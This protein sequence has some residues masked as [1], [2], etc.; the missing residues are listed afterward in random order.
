MQQ[1]KTELEE[2]LHQFITTWRLLARP[3]PH[4]DLSDQ[5][6]LAVSWPSTH[7]PFYNIVFL[8][9]ELKDEDVFRDRVREAVIHLRSSQASGLFLVCSYNLFCHQSRLKRAKK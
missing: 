8:T 9:E 1:T 7:F 4:A 3:F 5:P 2:S 6:G